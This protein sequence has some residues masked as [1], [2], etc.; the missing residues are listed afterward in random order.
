MKHFT[1]KIL[2]ALSSIA[3]MLVLAAGTDIKPVSAASG[4]V[5]IA[6]A[7]PH[8]K[9]PVTGKIEDAGGENSA[10]LGQSMTESATYKK[11]LVEVDGS[12]NTYITV[13]LQLMDN[14][15][16][17]QFQI[18][19]S[20]N[21]SFTSVSA[22]LMQEDYINN[23]ADYRMKVP[24]EKAI[25]R[26]NMY[27]TAMGRDV[28]FYITVSDLKQGSDDFITSI[29][30]EQQGAATETPK[31]ATTKPASSTKSPATAKATATP[32]AATQAPAATQKSTDSAKN[33][34]A[35]TVTP[36][37]LSTA[38]ITKA[39][40]TATSDNEVSDATGTPAQATAEISDESAGQTGQDSSSETNDLQESDD[41]K[42][43]ESETSSGSKV[44]GLKEFDASGNEVTAS[45]NDTPSSSAEK[46]DNNGLIKIGIAVVVILDAAI[47]F[48][49]W[50][51]KFFKKKGRVDR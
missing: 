25:I 37:A 17:P 13:R 5:Y 38:Q 45:E 21:G 29:S 26:C 48:G 31:A 22:T 23:T 12:G 14:I 44:V 51:F 27:V 35:P 11:A 41:A 43:D 4:G 50:Y 20:R 42:P 39:P 16:N 8:Y 15:E 6:V 40:D 30:V 7:T 9:H 18:D 3:V 10:V 24:S 28:I 47:A 46:E 32:S 2:F 1:S 36:S 34:A 19:G 49:I 33:T